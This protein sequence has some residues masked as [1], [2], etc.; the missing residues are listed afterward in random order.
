MIIYENEGNSGTGQKKSGELVPV[1]PFLKKQYPEDAYNQ[2]LDVITDAG[3]NDMAVANGPDIH[4]PVEGDQKSGNKESP[5][6]P[7]FFQRFDNPLPFIEMKGKGQR[8]A[9]CENDPVKQD[10]K[11]IHRH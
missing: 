1:H 3:L 7:L 2:R 10:Q 11:R 6:G 9:E 5:D 8:K 4:S